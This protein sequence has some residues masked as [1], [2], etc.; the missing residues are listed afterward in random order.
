VTILPVR[1]DSVAAMRS[2]EEI[3]HT[4]FRV[5]GRDMAELLENAAQ[6]MRALDG[7][8]AAQGSRWQRDRLKWK[9][10]T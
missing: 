1:L 4:A 3:D 8:R 10:S 5:Y 6:A 9:E 2:F 7:P